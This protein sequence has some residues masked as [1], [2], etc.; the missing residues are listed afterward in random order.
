MSISENKKKLI[1]WVD[2]NREEVFKLVSELV[3]IPSVLYGLDG[4]EKDCQLYIKEWFEKIGIKIDIFNPDEVPNLK[5]FNGYFNGLGNQNFKNRPNVV[6]SINGKGGGRSLILNGHIDVVPEEPMNWTHKPFGGEIT[7]DR[8]YGRGSVDM[9]GGLACTMIAIKCLRENNIDLKGNLIFESVVDE[10]SSISNGTLSCIA[11]GY[12]ADGV[13]ITEPNNL[14]ISP[15]SLGGMVFKITSKGSSGMGYGG[16]EIKEPVYP[17]GKIILWL[18]D[19]LEIIK[20]DFKPPELFIEEGKEMPVRISKVRAGELKKWGTPEECWIEIM[21]APWPG[22]EDDFKKH[23]LEHLNDYINSDI[24]LKKNPPKI[25]MV[26]RHQYGLDISKNHPLVKS[27]EKAYIKT[28]GKNPKIIG[29]PFA[30]DAYIFQKYSDMPAIVIGPGGRNA[31]ACDE[32]VYKKDLIEL[33]KILL[34]MIT[35]W[36]GI[37]N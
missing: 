11:R 5:K 31:H 35:D 36:C 2:I 20:R 6:A 26:S 37:N 15:A 30:C 8:I 21:A 23:F 29:A 25:E 3:Q 14:T 12:I 27:A 17:I 33:T 13:V 18:N 7:A 10:E 4:Y 22:V 24:L 9:K 32:F 16:E 19:Y 34:E 1:D 28:I